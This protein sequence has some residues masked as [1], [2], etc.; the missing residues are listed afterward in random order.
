MR[1]RMMHTERYSGKMSEP[2]KKLLMYCKAFWGVLILA[3][4]CDIAGVVARL[5]GPNQISRI[6]DLI[7]EGLMGEINL[8]A[9]VSVCW[10]LVGLYVGGTILGYVTV[11]I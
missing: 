2:L 11:V 8:D 3:V 4:V 7:S 10:L 6:T 9:V 5:L 1:G